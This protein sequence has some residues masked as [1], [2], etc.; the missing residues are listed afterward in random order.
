MGVAQSK[1]PNVQ[2]RMKRTECGWNSDSRTMKCKTWSANSKNANNVNNNANKLNNNNNANN[3][4]KN[5]NAKKKNNN[6]KK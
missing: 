4:N 2:F 1:Q 3:V 5:A 6:K